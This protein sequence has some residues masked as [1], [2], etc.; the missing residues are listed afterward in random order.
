MHTTKLITLL[1]LILSTILI[2]H[3]DNSHEDIGVDGAN[4]VDDDGYDDFV[5]AII[6]MVKDETQGR[7]ALLRRYLEQ[8]PTT[9]RLRARS[10]VDLTEAEDLL[11]HPRQVPDDQLGEAQ[12][13]SIP[14]RELVERGLDVEGITNSESEDDSFNPDSSDPY[15]IGPE[16]DE[17]T[18]LPGDTAPEPTQFKKITKRSLKELVKLA[19]GKRKRTI[20]AP[21]GTG[22]GKKPVY[23]GIAN[24]YD[25]VYHT[26]V[27]LGTPGTWFSVVIDT[28]SADLWVP[29]PKCTTQCAQRKKYVPTNSRTA[30]SLNV[31]TTV[32]YGLGSATGPVYMDTMRIGG[33]QATSTV[34]IQ[35]ESMNNNQ[36]ATVDGLLG[37]SFS[38][39]SWAN[40]AVPKANKGRSSIVENLWNQGQIPAA[41]FGIWLSTWDPARPTAQGGELTVGSAAGNPKRYTGA[42][43]WLSVPNT[44]NW[45]HI[46]VDQLTVGTSGSLIKGRTVRAIVDTGSAL[47]ITDYATA[48]AAN[49]QL[50]GYPTGIYGL[51]G[52]S[53]GKIKASTVAVTFTLGGRAFVLKGA[54]LASQVY[55]NDRNLCYS[56]F[57]TSRSGT[58]DNRWILGEIFLR[59]YYSIYDYNVQRTGGV[60]PR[61]GLALAVK[62]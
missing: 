31:R 58:D 57:M 47:L 22:W 50:G 18:G 44:S 41:A 51:W 60:L 1:L 27:Q 17:R 59:K 43:T 2:A 9:K 16:D 33:L 56:P 45:W 14:I 42:I 10:D 11:S 38:A 19:G 55:P 37:L 32:Y 30:Q 48:A 46:G 49:A 15:Y 28:G 25:S 35:A 8:D 4:I 13:A 23:G 52:I 62:G 36:P 40:Y 7:Q 20:T 54:D 5:P 24:Y 39:L 6:P 53:C 12:N 26:N 3:A 21:Y 29:S 61:V 34:F